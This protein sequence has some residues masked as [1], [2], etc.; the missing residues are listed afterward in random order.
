MIESQN[1]VVGNINA[2]ECYLKRMPILST[3]EC[4]QVSE[5]VIGLREH[6]VQRH[7][8]SIFYSLGAASY[9]DASQGRF[10]E[11][12]EKTKLYN[13]VLETHFDWL[14]KRL[15]QKFSEHLGEPCRYD[16]ALSYPGFHIFIGDGRT[17]GA[18][19]RHY[20]LQYDNIDWSSYGQVQLS[21]QLSYTLALRLPASGSGLYVWNVNDRA[22]RTLSP[23]ERK[24]HLEQNQTPAYEGYETG[25]M[26][27]HNGHYLHQIA[28]LRQMLE[29]QQRITLQGHAVWTESGWILY[30]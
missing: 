3:E 8:K 4:E 17:E 26:V 13:P 10:H 2:E 27:V 19:S 6:W 1:A 22:L 21:R 16:A 12:R 11:Y 14:Y 15:A 28:R 7:Q 18:A 20:D 30:W 25:Q 9:M 24:R 5:T 29:G 23:E